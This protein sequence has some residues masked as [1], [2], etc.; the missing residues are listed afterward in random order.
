MGRRIALVAKRNENGP[1]D[2]ADGFQLGRS[3]ASGNCE[4]DKINWRLQRVNPST[5]SKATASAKGGWTDAKWQ[6]VQSFPVAGPFDPL[7]W[8]VL[9]LGME[10]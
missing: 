3:G 7:L 10:W 1:A 8:S 4:A 5:G 9:D 6:M 2:Q